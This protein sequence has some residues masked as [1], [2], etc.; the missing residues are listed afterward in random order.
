MK[1]NENE[2]QYDVTV[3]GGGLTG[4]L[5]ISILI[6]SGIFEKSKL[7][8]INT[9]K[10]ISKD[11]R[12][13]FINYKNFF[14]LKKYYGIKFL[15]NEYLKINKIEIHNIDET[16]PLSLADEIG[17]GVIIRND[18][19]KNKIIISEDDLKIYKSKV[20]ST[21]HDEFH[22]YLFLENGIKINTSLV[23]SA[24]GNASSLR[25][26]SNIKYINYDL[27]HTIISGYLSSKNFDTNTAKQIF[28]KDSFIGLL[29]FS[30]NLTNFVW[31]LENQ[32]LY[33]KVNF[34]YY[35]EIIERLN[36]FFSRDNIIFDLPVSQN[37]KLQKYPINIKYV[38]YPFKKRL[39]LI[40]DAAHSIHPLA[41]QGFNLSME[42]CF[43]VMD[44]IRNA[45]NIGKDFGEISVL[46]EYSNKR[47][48][49]KNFITLITTILFYIFKKKNNL[50]N[51]ILNVSL[52]TLD[53]TPLK[54]LF[55][56]LARG[57]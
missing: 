24:D 19:F 27:D 7:C 33:K 10:K 49:R 25:K 14:K 18:I 3:I 6:K 43:D 51:K 8:W 4:K 47:K 15:T 2:K 42:D 57:Y 16:K 44:C 17:H 56:I 37:K 26:L 53:A 54:Q 52:Q 46:S 35:D 20:V 12:V 55:K 34:K 1:K 45:K 50:V 29:P 48:N 38:K 23:L 13:S 36:T 11:K 41:G 40:G 9:E 22:R 30:K 32:T 5:M 39:V 21:N 28:L 31:S